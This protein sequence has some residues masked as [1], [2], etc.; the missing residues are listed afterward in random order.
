MLGVLVDFN[1]YLSEITRGS[2]ERES[3]YLWQPAASPIVAHLRRLDLGEVPVVS[4]QLSRGD[5]GFPEPLATILSVG[6]VVL[7]LVA[8]LGLWHTLRRAGGSSAE[9]VSLVDNQ[10]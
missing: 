10:A 3:I 6:M 8:L 9:P 2:M 1:V 7:V 4:F 5:I